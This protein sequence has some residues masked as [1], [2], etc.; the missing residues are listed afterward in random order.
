[1]KYKARTLRGAER[2]VQ[3]LRREREMILET[4]DVCLNERRKLARLSA[5]GG[6]AF[7]TL[8]QAED[9]RSIRDMILR[10]EC[11]CDVYGIDREEDGG[12]F[13]E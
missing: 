10:E 4:L 5:E 2:E 13:D 12:D 7:P 9:A 6:P 11:G 3:R 1:M 8:L